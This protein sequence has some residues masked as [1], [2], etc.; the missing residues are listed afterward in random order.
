METLKLEN[1][2]TITNTFQYNVFQTRKEALQF[3]INEM[4]WDEDDVLD[5][6]LEISV[7]TQE[8]GIIDV[9]LDCIMVDA[10]SDDYLYFIQ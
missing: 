6:N 3:G 7:N 10:G 1:G 4:E 8:E 5:R 2:Q 9:N